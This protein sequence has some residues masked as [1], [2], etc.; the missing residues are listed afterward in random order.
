MLL[1]GAMSDMSIS[2][3]SAQAGAGPGKNFVSSDADKMEDFTATGLA[4]E[5]N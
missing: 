1:E 2:D 4:L 5:T 3:Y